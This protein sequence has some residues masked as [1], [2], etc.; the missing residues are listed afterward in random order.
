MFRFIPLLI[1]IVGSATSLEQIS[2]GIINKNVER[3][4]DLSSQLVKITSTITIENTGT[5]PESSILLFLEPETIG[6][7]SYIGAKD[8]LKTALTHE[9]AVVAG[10]EKNG[11]AM[12][13]HLGEP[14]LA[15]RT[16]SVHVEYIYR[17][18]LIP[19]PSSIT[20][21]DK[22]L[23]KYVG[24]V[25][26]YTPY[27]TARQTTS[28]ILNSRHVESF[29]KLKP[30]SQADSTITYGPYTDIA[31]LAHIELLVHYE[32]NAP[33]LTVTRLERSIEVSHWGNVAVE[34]HV[35]IVHTGARLKGSFSRYDYQRDSGSQH[36]VK[37]YRTV[38]PSTAH[39]IYYRDSNG[40]ISTSAVRV[41]SEWID[42]EL[43]PRFP[44]F[45]GWRSAYTL[46][47]S[48]PAHQY[49][50][51]DGRDGP[52]RF[53]VR[54]RLLDHVFD[55]MQ[56]DELVMQIVLPVGV[57]NVKVRTPFEVV[58]R[59]AD[60]RTHKYLDRLGRVVVRLRANG[61]VEQHM[62]DVE[63]TYEWKPVLL[64]HEP[65]CLALALFVLFAAVIVW[66]RIDCSLQKKYVKQ[67]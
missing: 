62:Q 4:I 52:D 57:A 51:R 59:L 12:K 13:V 14:L 33:F 15:G 54:I 48:V 31:P 10:H 21:K 19:S 45:G 26:A 37:S 20:Q 49:L 16:T 2:T 55:D 58:E 11:F 42:L 43:R 6:N 3:I 5:K 23:V 66:V 64:L 63:V 46:G 44:L 61:L 38:L 7:L 65:I 22:Q 41:R 34:E 30:F 50:F 60:G 27:K 47:Y 25:Y 36:S 40:N 18:A 9:K 32:N 67:Q 8:A 39:S 35:E 53:S 1:F 28:L 24:S 17:N 29:T 56:V